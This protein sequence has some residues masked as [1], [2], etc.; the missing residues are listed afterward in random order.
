M[1]DRLKI[2]SEPEWE[3]CVRI[4][5]VVFASLF[6]VCHPASADPMTL[7]FSWRGARGCVTLFP[8]PEIRL[9]NVPAGATSISFT[10]TQGAREM[11]GQDVPVPSN[12][13]LPFGAIRTFGPCNPGLYEWT[14]LAK[15]STGQVLSKAHQERF[16]PADE[17][18]MENDST[19]MP[20]AAGRARDLQPT[21]VR[22]R[23]R[24]PSVCSS[25]C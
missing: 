7:D 6:A 2:G 4:V 8:N 17:P 13:I 3:R 21:P 24:S 1:V 23:A 5:F 11:G 16:Y 25:G 22:E 14:A 20:P 19:A 12:G 9:R 18:A 10:L 15:S